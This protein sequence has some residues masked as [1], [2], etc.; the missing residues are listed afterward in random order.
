MVSNNTGR[1]TQ[2]IGSTLDAAFDEDK[3]PAIYNAL[4]VG[5][6][7]TVVEVEAPRIER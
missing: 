2:V 6:E 3:L 1:V 4:Q 7:R 5:V